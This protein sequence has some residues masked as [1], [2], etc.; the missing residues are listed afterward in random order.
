MAKTIILNVTVVNEGQEYPNSCILIE[1]GIIKKISSS[2]IE[3]DDAE[4]IDG[5]GGY[6]IPG[7]IDDQVHFR[8]P[9][10]THKAE[11]Y[12]EAK[13]AV[14][15]GVTTYMEMPNTTPQA[16]TIEELEKKYSRAAEVSL[17][18]YSFYMGATNDNLEELLKVDPTKVCGVK[19]FMGSSTGNMLVDRSETLEGIFKGVKMLI[20]TH[21]EDE[22]TIQHNTKLAKDKYGE[23]VP[24][25]E[26]PN[27]RSAEACYLSSSKA[28]KL[29]KKFGTKLHVLHITTEKEMELFSTED[30]KDKKITCEVC[31]HHLWFNETDYPKYGTRIKWNPAVKAK[32]DQEALIK[33]VK[34]GRI[35]VIATDHAP[36]TDEEKEN[37]YFKAPSGGPLV[38][39]SVPAMFKLAD[40]KLFTVPQ[41]V[42]KMC[43]NPAILYQ[44]DK[45]GYIKE[46]YHADI[47][48]VAKKD[49]I[50]EKSNIHYK[51]G[52]SPF[53]GSELSHKITHT[54]VNGNLVYKNVGKDEL[55]FE[56]IKGSRILFDR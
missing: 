2:P 42:E 39:H 3:A 29:A 5:D 28:V 19:V 12:T 37:S 49:W 33:A 40:D 55:F 22:A 20:A 21:C 36:H 30:L 27:I 24:I 46:G 44:I 35:D 1:N 43:H 14:S 45:R 7:A 17:A 4:I 34:D 51:C 9:G 23:D 54:F 52:W 10:L 13:A 50:V 8:E 38:Q 56:N 15:G 48:I 11:I 16:T 18:N 41:I 6:A 25:S 32:S 26:H 47:A 53:E 31:V